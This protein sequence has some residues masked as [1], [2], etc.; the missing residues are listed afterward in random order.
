MRVFFVLKS[1]KKK[2]EEENSKIT[3][4]V[5]V[6]FSSRDRINVHLSLFGCRVQFFSCVNYRV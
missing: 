3:Y 2:H 6:I 5:I 1:K 4:I